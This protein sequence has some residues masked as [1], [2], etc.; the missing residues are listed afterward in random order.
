MIDK[1]KHYTYETIKKGVPVVT[2]GALATSCAI[3][4]PSEDRLPTAEPVP[5]TLNSPSA[6]M[7]LNVPL[8]DAF[9]VGNVKVKIK[10]SDTIVEGVDADNGVF[11]I[12]PVLEYKTKPAGTDFTSLGL[13]PAYHSEL[14]GVENGEATQIPIIGMSDIGYPIYD[15]EGYDRY[16][17][18]SGVAA[19]TLEGEFLASSE[20]LSLDLKIQ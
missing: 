1:I 20:C 3:D 5:S 8:T 16:T 11:A 17:V 18:K 7:D 19:K 9:S 14:Y 2:I 10:C 15:F 4:K 6:S 13:E 12:K